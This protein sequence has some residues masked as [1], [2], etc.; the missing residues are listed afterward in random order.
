MSRR[1]RRGSGQALVEFAMVMPVF[2]LLLFGLLDFGRVVFAQNTVS[3]AAREASR[4]ASLEPSTSKY[5]AIRQAAIRMAPGLGLS[6]ADVT[7]AGCADCFYPDGTQAGGRAVVTVRARIDLLTPIISQL[8]GLVGAPSG[9]AGGRP[10]RP[11][12][13]AGHRRRR[14]ALQCPRSGP[15]SGG[16]QRRGRLQRVR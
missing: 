12:R 4:Y 16:G 6:D 3:Q 11:R 9:A 14:N 15:R 1:K 5:A 13:R 2:M 8:L 10:R 7:G